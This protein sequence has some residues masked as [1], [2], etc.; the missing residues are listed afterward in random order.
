MDIQ[1]RPT[2]CLAACSS[3]VPEHPVSLSRV[4][5]ELTVNIVYW[6]PH[7]FSITNLILLIS[8]CMC[9]GMPGHIPKHMSQTSNNN[10]II[11]FHVMLLDWD[12]FILTLLVYIPPNMLL[13]WFLY[14]ITRH[15]CYLY[16]VERCV[17][18]SAT[19]HTWWGSP[20]RIHGVPLESHIA[21][22][23]HQSSGPSTW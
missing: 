17:E 6:Y 20:L 1:I 23:T 16:T 7:Q 9:V 22:S 14:H 12:W 8:G 2:L 3:S 4:C 5:T 19:S 21:S 15:S 13:V 18:L 10:I 11:W